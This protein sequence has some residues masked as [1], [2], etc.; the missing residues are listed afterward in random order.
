MSNEYRYNP[1]SELQSTKE[2]ISSVEDQSLNRTR[3]MR[4]LLSETREVGTKTAEEL[5]LQGE[6]LQN[7]NRTLDDINEDL[8]A[9]QKEINKLKGF[10]GR[11]KSKFSSSKKNDLNSGSIAKSS[12]SDDKKQKKENGNLKFENEPYQK[13]QFVSITGSDRE[14]GTINLNCLK[15]Y[16]I[17]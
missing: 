14:K 8:T 7:I 4:Q 15:N 5:V 3:A 12:K 6:K 2:K 1:Q 9:N 17:Y 13:P 11:I 16:N 10:F